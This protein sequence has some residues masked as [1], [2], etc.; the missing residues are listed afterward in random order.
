VVVGEIFGRKATA[1]VL[2]LISVPGIDV[3]PG[4]FHR[5]F[6]A[7]DQA[8][9]SHHGRQL[10]GETDGMDFPIILLDHLH[11]PETKH[12]HRFFPVDDLERLVGDVQEEYLLH[13]ARSFF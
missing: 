4:K 6:R 9:Q 2:A 11:L 1:A 3:L 7:L 5:A 8:E 13:G 12:G 10:D